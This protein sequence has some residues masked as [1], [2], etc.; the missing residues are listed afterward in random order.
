MIKGEGVN[1]CLEKPYT[2]N[3][4]MMKFWYNFTRNNFA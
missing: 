4:G 2:K 1:G 3:S